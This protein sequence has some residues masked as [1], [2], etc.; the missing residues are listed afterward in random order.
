MP[1]AENRTRGEKM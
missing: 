1:V